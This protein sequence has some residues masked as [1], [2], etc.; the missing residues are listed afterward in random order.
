MSKM[1]VL[2][3]SRRLGIV[4]MTSKDRQYSFWDTLPIDK[5][6]A[7]QPGAIPKGAYGSIFDL[8]IMLIIFLV[9]YYLG[10]Y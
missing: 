7:M 8:L 1:D 4:P 3:S 9:C 10:L 5:W 2:H 6:F